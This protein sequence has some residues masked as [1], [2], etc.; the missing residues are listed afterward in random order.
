M[1]KIPLTK[2]FVA[3][4]DDEDYARVSQYKWCA[5][6]RNNYDTV[7]AVRAVRIG[8]KCKTIMLH[9][10]ILNL[11]RSR[12]PEVDHKDNNGLNNQKQNLRIC[13]YSENG[14]NQRKTRGASSKYKGVHWD[15]G[16]SKWR[17]EINVAGCR[18]SLGRFSSEEE[19]G[20][21]YDKAAYR[22]FGSFAKLN[23]GGSL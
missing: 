6:T 14:A 7:Y 10:L 1:K 21:A 15:K 23:F 5:L 3:L 20:E 11:P 17:S 12:K 8:G 19:A 16:R 18:I 13:T 9:R 4:V 22:A 2:G